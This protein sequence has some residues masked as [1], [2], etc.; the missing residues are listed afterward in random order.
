MQALVYAL[1]SV[2][3]DRAGPTKPVDASKQ[4]R[5]QSSG[6]QLK[7]WTQTAATY[8]NGSQRTQMEVD[9][10]LTFLLLGPL[11]VVYPMRLRGL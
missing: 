4:V 3:A 2:S 6:T 9:F 7:P 1:Q 5:F 11:G 10:Y 8:S